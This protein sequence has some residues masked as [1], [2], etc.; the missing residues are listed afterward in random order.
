MV[1]LV[2]IYESR[3][4]LGKQRVKTGPKVS[5][6]N[7]DSTGYWNTFKGGRLINLMEDISR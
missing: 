7:K 4:L 1:I 2:G 3:I 6:S 5:H